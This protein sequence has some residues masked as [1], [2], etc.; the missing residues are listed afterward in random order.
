[1]NQGWVWLHRK[2][3]EWEWYRDTNVKVVFIHLLLSAN[4]KD[5]RWRGT[6]IKRGQLITSYQH[7]SEDLGFGVQSVRTAIKKL[8]STGEITYQTTNKYSI[9]TINN[10]NLYNSNNMLANKQLTSNQQATNK[11]LTT[12]NND[13]NVKN[14]K[15]KII[16]SSKKLLRDKAKEIISYWNSAHNRKFAVPREGGWLKNLKMWLETYTVDDIKKAIDVAQTK[17]SFYKDKITPDMLFRT[18]EDRIGQMLNYKFVSN[19][20]GG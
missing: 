4:H 20:I 17:H 6:L 7:L 18:H 12:N 15:N 16:M 1:M 3:K 8:K 13:N 2:I 11:Q 10:Y 5:K 9:I 14:E 19:V